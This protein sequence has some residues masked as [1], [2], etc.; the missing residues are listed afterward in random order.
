M[1]LYADIFTKISSIAGM[2][3]LVGRRVF[4]RRA[5][6]GTETPYIVYYAVGG[7]P[8]IAL[9]GPT[10]LDKKRVQV[11]IYA[12]TSDAGEQVADKVRTLHGDKSTWGDHDMQ[13][14]FVMDDAD[15]IEPSPGAEE[16]ARIIVSLMLELN[17][18]EAA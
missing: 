6:Q 17:Y 13:A 7:S 16:N 3:A 14:C 5:D 1:S 11:D 4:H 9:D 12:D 2:S 18:S 10:G 15:D 8:G